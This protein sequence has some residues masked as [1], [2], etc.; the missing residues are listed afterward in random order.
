MSHGKLSNGMKFMT[1]NNIGKKYWRQKSRRWQ[2]PSITHL[3]C[4]CF[5][6]FNYYHVLHKHYMDIVNLWKLYLPQQSNRQRST[7]TSPACMICIEITLYI[8]KHMLWILLNVHGHELTNN[9]EKH[10]IQDVFYQHQWSNHESSS[11]FKLLRLIK[12]FQ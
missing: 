9:T 10:T 8:P 3:C 1:E 2:K 7:F 6:N 4:T 12:L 5:L 11:W